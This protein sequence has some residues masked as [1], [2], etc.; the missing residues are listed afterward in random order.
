MFVSKFLITKAPQSIAKTMGPYTH[1]FAWKFR[2]FMA[3]FLF[4]QISSEKGKM[5]MMLKVFFSS[6]FFIIFIFTCLN[7]IL[8]SLALY[9]ACSSLKLLYTS[10]N[11]AYHEDI[12][13]PTS[14]HKRGFSHKFKCLLMKISRLLMGIS[15]F[16]ELFSIAF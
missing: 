4:S 10:S 8:L 14:D 5:A 3:Y 15:K 6:G 1:V 9:N 7:S 16:H 2:N 11:S 12:I 13:K